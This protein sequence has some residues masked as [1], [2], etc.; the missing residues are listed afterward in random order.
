MLKII[1]SF[2]FAVLN[3]ILINPQLTGSA[4][5]ILLSVKYS[6]NLVLDWFGVLSLFMLVCSASCSVDAS[7]PLNSLR[8]VCWPAHIRIPSRSCLQF[9]WR[10]TGRTLNFFD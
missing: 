2:A 10:S 4:S 5:P 6:F 8:T 1:S 7:S 9:Y 3:F